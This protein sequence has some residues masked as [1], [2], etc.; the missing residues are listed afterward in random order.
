MRGDAEGDSGVDGWRWIKMLNGVR[1]EAVY[2]SR[3]E[4]SEGMIDLKL[5]WKFNLHVTS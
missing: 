1:A 5:E 3:V 4:L 2:S